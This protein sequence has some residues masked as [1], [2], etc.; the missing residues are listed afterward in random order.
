MMVLSVTTL[1]IRPDRYEDFLENT[2]KS[3]SILEK[4]G[5]KNVRLIVSMSGQIS[6]SFVLTHEADDHAASGAI[7]DRFL[8]DSDG[9]A[10]LMESGTEGGPTASWQTSSWVEI[11]L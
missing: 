4:C 10:L 7:L 9:L 6:G 2:K 5:A 8:A 1:T 11:P 3:K